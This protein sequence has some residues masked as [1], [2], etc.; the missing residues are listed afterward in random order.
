MKDQE[1]VVEQIRRIRSINIRTYREAA[2]A[3]QEAA[4]LADRAFQV[5][6]PAVV[7]EGERVDREKA[8]E[9][10][11]RKKELAAELKEASKIIDEVVE[12]P[13]ET[14]PTDEKTEK[15]KA[16]RRRVAKI[17]EAMDVVPSVPKED[18]ASKEE[19]EAGVPAGEAN[20]APASF[21]K[22]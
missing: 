15:T 4:A 1:S 20:E 12:A 3:I 10:L 16:T 8:K 21:E 7:L 5:A 22:E 18:E 14:E 2:Y 9:A 17:K 6:F 13:K 11:K 19:G